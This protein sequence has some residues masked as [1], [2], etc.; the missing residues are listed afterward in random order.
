M[1]S[2]VM[3]W[4]WR[5]TRTAEEHTNVGRILDDHERRLKRNEAGL[6]AIQVELGIFKPHGE[7]GARANDH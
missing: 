3:K 5:Q 7:Q 6:R 4:P 2:S 1:E